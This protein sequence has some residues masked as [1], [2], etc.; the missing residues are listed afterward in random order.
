MVISDISIKRP[1]FATVLSLILVLVGIVS[2]NSLSVREYPKIDPPIVSVTTKYPGASPEI[3]ESQVTQIL[4]ESLAGIEG[5]ELMTSISR[6]E[7]SQISIRFLLDRDP[8]DAASDVRDRTGRVRGR[9]PDEIDEPIIQKTE[10]DAQPTI[11]ISFF[12]DRFS[13]L[14]IS[15]F[16]DRYVKEAL[17][18]LPGVAEVRIFGE[19]RYSMRIWL[20][21]ERMAAYRLTTQDVEAALRAQNVEIPSG[22]VESQNREFSVLSESDLRT[23]A[24]FNDMILRQADGYLVRLQDVGR[25]ELGAVDERRINRFNRRTS[26][27]VG[28]VKQSTA[29]PLEISDLVQ[30]ELPNVL[31][32][33]PEGM[34]AAVAY[35]RALFIKTSI[36]NVYHTI[37]EAVVLVILI[38]FLFLRSL[39][40]T[41]IPL[42]TIPVS[43]IGSCAIMLALGFSINT[44]TLLALVL[45]IGLVVDDAI[46]MLEN[47][48]RHVEEGMSPVRAAF[49]GSREIAFAVIGMTLTLAAVY[50]PIGFITGTT[51]KLFT[52]FAWTLAGS[53]LISGF[54][55]LTLSPMMCSV[56]LRHQTTHGWFYNA[57]E[58]VLEGMRRGY[59][60]LLWSALRARWLVLGVGIA[61]AGFAVLVFG[62]LKSELAPIEDQGTIAVLGTAPEGATL[63]YTD[64]YARQIEDILG[65]VPEIERSL[66]ISG[67]PTVQNLISFNRLALWDDRDRKQQEITASLAPKMSQVAGLRAFATNPAPLGQSIRSRPVE[68]VIQT[69]QSYRDLETMVEEILRRASQNARLLN[70]DTD[71]KLNSPQIRVAIDREKAADLGIPVATVGRTLETMLGSRQVTRFKREGKQYD[72]I[73]QLADVDRRNPQDLARIHVRAAGGQMVPLSNLVRIEEG[74]A[75]R[76]LNHF[77]QRRSATIS[78]NL[79]DGYALGEALGFLEG[80]ARDVLPATAAIDYNGQ[81]REFKQAS[82][83]LVFV[84]ALALVFIYLVLAAQFE[85]FRDPLTIML[86]VPLSMAG[87]LAALWWFGGT[88]NI[89]SQV[90]LVTL[91]GLITKHG[92]LIV[93]FAN[94]IRAS[95]REMYEAVVEAASLRL[96]PILMTTGAM[97][98]G[99]LPLAIAT[100]AGAESRSQIGI[101][102]VGGLLVGTFFTLF[103]IPAAYTLIASRTVRADVHGDHAGHDH[104]GHAG[105]AHDAPHPRP[106]E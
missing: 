99:A 95:G 33:L 10:A 43:L 21:P 91:I 96:R 98:L 81:S 51:G 66:V 79:A 93:E 60:R 61:V 89:Y 97:V 12:S 36:E 29:N 7:Q 90:G 64:T 106:A 49:Q 20:D 9:L 31:A 17:Q 25:A 71:L 87:A 54:V 84:F 40:A 41:L 83:S 26:I 52:E 19:R 67:S 53:V 4:E 1:V 55:A 5:I 62:Q 37:A 14:E 30:R 15:D 56:L 105:Q 13:Q 82:S 35:D 8:D 102:I 28:V 42:V 38:I 59:R 86:T 85:S 78:A 22:R 77:D 88:L 18:T 27:T 92:I 11:Y 101:V 63:Q 65:S 94:Q 48:Y 23:P 44:L 58:N 32:A 3:I 73:L 6:Q 75:P 39:R 72:V 47:I 80:I 50:A 34:E 70:L 100:G 74:I 16:A 57:V 104:S 46:V 69:S 24:Q 76:E 103:V 45:A 68:M 2:Y